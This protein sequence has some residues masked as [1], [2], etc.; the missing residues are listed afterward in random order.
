MLHCLCLSLYKAVA[1]LPLTQQIL[2]PGQE[3]SALM[4]TTTA[5]RSMLL[6]LAA[7]RH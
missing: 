5:M 3:M 6:L 1:A 7:V 4:R 2:V